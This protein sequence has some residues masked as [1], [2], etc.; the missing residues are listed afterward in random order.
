MTTNTSDPHDDIKVIF[1][2]ISDL[3]KEK[4]DLE[5]IALLSEHLKSDR[6]NSAQLTQLLS[7]EKSEL[8]AL[9]IIR[10]PWKFFYTVHP[11]LIKKLTGP[12]LALVL[13]AQQND[14]DHTPLTLLAGHL[15]SAFDKMLSDIAPKLSTPDLTKLFSQET[16]WG[17]TSLSLLTIKHSKIFVKTLK[18]LEDKL[19][20]QALTDILK[21]RYFNGDPALLLVKEYQAF[22]DA[23]QILAPLLNESQLAEIL[24]QQEF[25]GNTALSFT[26]RGRP[27]IFM[28]IFQLFSPEQKIAVLTHNDSHLYQAIQKMDDA[29][30]ADL[31]QKKEQA[32]KD[33]I[34]PATIKGEELLLPLIQKNLG[35]R[36]YMTELTKANGKLTKA[37][38]TSDGAATV[39]KELTFFDN[40]T[41]RLISEKDGLKIRTEKYLEETPIQENPILVELITQTGNDQIWTINQW[42]KPYIDSALLHKSSKEHHQRNG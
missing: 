17:F 29:K 32:R 26:A 6:L 34:D 16:H 23:V 20:P 3:F 8:L 19:E 9:A 38:Q 30:R 41:I 1:K 37:I 40:G 12:Q 39:T 21:K 4:K 31:K 22:H 13:G 7:Q 33:G 15:P 5:A 11:H 2:E 28:A 24:G 18:I 36:I 14:R 25:R 42:K 35:T 10:N 27:D